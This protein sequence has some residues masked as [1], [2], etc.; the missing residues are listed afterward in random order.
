MAHLGR[1]LGAV[2]LLGQDALTPRKRR[3]LKALLAAGS[4]RA[5]TFEREMWHEPAAR[6]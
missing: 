1:G 6:I 5:G 3:Q 2:R 4:S